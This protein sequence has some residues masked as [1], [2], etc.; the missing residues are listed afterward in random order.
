MSTHLNFGK[1]FSLPVDGPIFAQPLYM[2]G[3]TV[4]TQIHNLV[5]VATE[6]NCV[7]AWDADT[8]SSTPVW[9][10]QLHQS[11]R[12]GYCDSLC[13]GRVGAGR[14][15]NHHAGVWDH[16]H[17]G[18]RFFDGNVVCGGQHQGSFRKHD[19][20]CVPA[21]CAE[22][23]HGP[24]EVWRP[25]GNPSNKR[26]GHPRADTTPSAASAIAGEWCGLYRV[27]VSRRHVAVVRLAT[28]LQRQH[29]ATSDGI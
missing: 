22:C 6:H 5:F 10:C 11:G 20:L 28:G 25:R 29:V 16:Q 2:P 3:V 26:V 27:W 1:L 21:A 17:A 8:A 9:T 24:R 13:G 15:L 18:D 4:G 19:E 12:W 14:L 23:H 7:Y